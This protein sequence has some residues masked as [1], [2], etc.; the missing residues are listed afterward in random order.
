MGDATSRS[1][2][3]ARKNVESAVMMLESRRMER[4]ARRMIPRTLP[5]MRFP[6]SS[7]PRK[8]RSTR[9]A[10]PNT[11]V[12]KTSATRARTMARTPEP[13]CFSRSR[14]STLRHLGVSTVQTCGRTAARAL[15]G[16]GVENGVELMLP[17]AAGELQEQVFQPQLLRRGL[18]PD[19]GHRA[20]RHDPAAMDNGKPVAHRL[21]NFERVGAHQHSA[22]AVDKLAE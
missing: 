1:R 10:M 16:S 8:Y 5:A 3:L 12:Q 2:S 7:T 19:L 9:Y 21:G 20:M 13:A 22:A 15:T 4:K 17:H 14:A 11:A 6:I 18:L